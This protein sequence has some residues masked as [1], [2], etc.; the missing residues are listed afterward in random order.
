M[1][2]FSYSAGTHASCLV[3]GQGDA[4]KAA[5]WVNNA[6]VHASD[7]FR[8]AWLLAVAR[9]A[10]ACVTGAA[11]GYIKNS[12]PERG[13]LFVLYLIQCLVRYR[14]DTWNANTGEHM[15][16]V[17]VD[18]AT[19]IVYFPPAVMQDPAI[20]VQNLVAAGFQNTARDGPPA[21]I[22]ANQAGAGALPFSKGWTPA[23]YALIEYAANANL[24]E[25]YATEVMTLVGLQ[26]A[27]DGHHV[28]P[29][30]KTTM[31]LLSD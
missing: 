13:M 23:E 30:N 7:I 5:E 25:C 24:V 1:P 18:L 14:L 21:V 10:T 27:A 12:I 26:L 6:T 2:A 11:H 4:V 16:F 29:N 9:D 20:F 19:G 31:G 22:A 28:D 15:N 3:N 8:Y 17:N